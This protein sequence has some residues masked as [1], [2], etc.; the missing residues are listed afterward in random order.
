MVR[1]YKGHHRSWITNAHMQR[2]GNR[3]LVTGE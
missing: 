2:G 1:S 3:E